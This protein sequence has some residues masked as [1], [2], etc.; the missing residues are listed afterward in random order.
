LKDL[1]FT[2]EYTYISWQLLIIYLP[3]GTYSV[4]VPPFSDD[5]LPRVGTLLSGSTK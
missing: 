1:S 3:R 2:E 5:Y 4:Y